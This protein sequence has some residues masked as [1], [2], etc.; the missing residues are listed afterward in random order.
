M[1]T[2]LKL[3]FVLLFTFLLFTGCGKSPSIDKDA[4]PQ[5]MSRETVFDSGSDSDLDFSTDTDNNLDQS[6]SQKEVAELYRSVYLASY[7][8]NNVSVTLSSEEISKI[9]ALL[10]S[11][12]FV[13]GDGAG[14]FD[15]SNPQ[16]VFDFFDAMQ[17]K[18]GAEICIY[19]IYSDGG[20]FSHSIKSSASGITVV[21]TRL[22]WLDDGEFAL[23][24]ENPTVTF[25]DCFEV[26]DISLTDGYLHYEY[27]I[28]NNPS[29]TNHD[30]HID[31]VENI[32]I[33]A[34]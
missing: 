1:K 26:T 28:P 11:E 20:F 16:L 33:C 5:E 13:A 9:A 17:A 6:T 30:G 7:K 25:T 12:G 4:S 24:G 23:P 19:Q 32:R 29:G 27:Y 3:L 22:A 8:G 31:P 2:N 34:K 15:V 14:S 18:Q 10:G 21:Q